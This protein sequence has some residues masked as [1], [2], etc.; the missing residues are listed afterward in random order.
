MSGTGEIMLLS[1][2][3]GLPRESVII[4]PYAREMDVIGS[5]A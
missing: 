1:I 4:S 5:Y 3:A 2:S